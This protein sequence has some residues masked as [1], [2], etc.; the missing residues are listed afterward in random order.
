MAFI[1]VNC[2]D[3]L[4]PVSR[5]EGFME[6]QDLN[7]RSFLQTLGATSLLSALPESAFALRPA[8]ESQ[9]HEAVPS[10]SEPDAKPR[11]SIKFA[12]CGMR[13]DHIYGMIGAVQ[14]GGGILVAAYGQ[15]LDKLAIFT[16]RFPDVR[17]VSSEDEI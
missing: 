12:V 14:R 8:P 16:K 6:N 2:A 7:R 5:V 17:M 11:Y 3:K 9:A 1:G 4:Y 15:E 10:A 13:H